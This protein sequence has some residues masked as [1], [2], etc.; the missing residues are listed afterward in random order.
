MSG[1]SMR[2]LVKKL[3][4]TNPKTKTEPAWK[5]PAVEYPKD[6]TI[7]EIPYKWPEP[8]PKP[9]RAVK[10]KRKPGPKPGRKR[11]SLLS[12]WG[13]ERKEWKEEQV[14]TLIRMYN[15]GKPLLEIAEATGHGENSIGY[16]LQK[17][18]KAGKVSGNRNSS[19]G[20]KQEQDETMLRMR[21]QGAT[22]EEIGMAVGKSHA[23]TWSRYKRIMKE[24]RKKE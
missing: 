10:P 4:E 1:A 22:Y 23:A 17:L 24:M 11:K 3:P 8:K 20:W 6:A 16:K 19:T 9:E 18:R 5:K 2:I 13:N 14:E 15:E 7:I 12:C 21:E